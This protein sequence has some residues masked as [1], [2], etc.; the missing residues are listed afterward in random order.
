[1]VRQH[2][3]KR[4]RKRRKIGAILA[5]CESIVKAA[6]VSKWKVKVR[7]EGNSYAKLKS[8]IMIIGQKEVERAE[9]ERWGISKERLFRKKR[10]GEGNLCGVNQW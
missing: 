9:K 4:E 7:K 3:F 8:T 10:A 6:L 1:M 5:N 2:R